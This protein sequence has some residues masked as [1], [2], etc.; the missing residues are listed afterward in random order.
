MQMTCKP[1]IG[2]VLFYLKENTGGN[3]LRF[4]LLIYNLPAT[5][6]AAASVIF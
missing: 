6:T 4:F 5:T 1:I 3:I 2:D